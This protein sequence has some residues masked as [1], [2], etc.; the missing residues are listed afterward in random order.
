MQDFLL[1]VLNVWV[2]C[3]VSKSGDW[4]E[5]QVTGSASKYLRFDDALFVRFSG[6]FHNQSYMH[7]I[8]TPS[9]AHI[10]RQERFYYLQIS[11][12]H[13]SFFFRCDN[14]I[15]ERFTRFRDLDDNIISVYCL[16]LANL[17]VEVWFTKLFYS[18]FVCIILLL[19]WQMFSLFIYCSKVAVKFEWMWFHKNCWI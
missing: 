19:L 12:L 10:Q 6:L 15:F 9:R 8:L 11:K 13:Q 17:T 3:D 16:K 14:R 1:A 7:F 5:L 2:K 18:F 4:S